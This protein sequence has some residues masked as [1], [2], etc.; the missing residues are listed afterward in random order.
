[1]VEPTRYRYTECGIDNIYLLNGFDFVDTPRG[2]SVKIRDVEGLHRA[3]GMMLVRDRQS[4]NGQEFRFLRHELNQTQADLAAMLGVSVQSV[5]RWEKGRTKD[6]IDGPAQRLLRLLYREYV[7]GN[8]DIVEPLRELAQL[9]E[10][11]CDS[12]EEFGFENQD[13]W[14]SQIAA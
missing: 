12:D 8:K 2:A 10:M 13:G 11:F 9:D 4:L 6:T 14:Q 7:V 3:I 5:A 1:M